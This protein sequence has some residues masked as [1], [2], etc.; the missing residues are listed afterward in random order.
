M[1][2]NEK[3]SDCDDADVRSQ[4]NTHKNRSQ[5]KREL[6]MLTS[7]TR[8]RVRKKPRHNEE[9]EASVQVSHSDEGN[10]LIHLQS[11][12][13]LVEENAVCRNCHSPLQFT[14][15]TIGIATSMILSCEKC[16]I[17]KKTLNMRTKMADE[18]NEST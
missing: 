9:L 10:R 6:Q 16:K 8:S 2:P 3:E 13:K 5:C 12:V 15:N 4:I 7:I 14:E 1:T 17:S 18:K 11:L